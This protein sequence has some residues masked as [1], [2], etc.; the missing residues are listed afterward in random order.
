[1]KSVWPY[2]S[3]NINKGHEIRP[4]LRSKIGFASCCCAPY[5]N[6]GGP[7]RIPRCIATVWISYNLFFFILSSTAFFAFFSYC[8]LI[9]IKISAF[10]FNNVF[11]D[12][13]KFFLINFFVNGG[14]GFSVLPC[15]MIFLIMI[16]LSKSW[17]IRFNIFFSLHPVSIYLIPSWYRS[18]AINA[19]VAR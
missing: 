5:S 8:N 16:L 14:G 13:L 19:F 2:S 12:F 9:F 7:I 10:N 17:N 6:T 15:F 3:Y 1:M 18:N 11:A 4:V